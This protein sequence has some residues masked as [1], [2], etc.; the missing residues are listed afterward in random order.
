VKTTTPGSQ[1]AVIFGVRRWQISGRR[2]T[3]I[4][5]RGG[6]RRETVGRQAVRNGEYRN[7]GRWA[8]TTA[9]ATFSAD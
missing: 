9:A 8:A 7:G 5:R 2:A 4:S 1:A 3:V 6:G